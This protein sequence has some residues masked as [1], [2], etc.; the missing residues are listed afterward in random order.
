[1]PLQLTSEQVWEAMKKEVFAVVG[2]VTAKNE[3]RTVGIMYAIHGGKLLF[4][5]GRETW[6]VR[7]MSANPHVSVTIPIAKRVPFMPWMKIPAATIT[8]SG[9]ARVMPDG[10]VTPDLLRTVFRQMAEDEAFM[11]GNCLVEVTPVG[12]FITYGVG[13]SLMQMRYPE[14][15]RGRAPAEVRKETT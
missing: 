13:V 8:F 9:T 10:E 7:H 15:A 1:M 6:K 2:M 14:K 3:A 12:D 5:T 4:G 11:A